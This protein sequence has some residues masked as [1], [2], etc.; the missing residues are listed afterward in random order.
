MSQSEGRVPERWQCRLPSGERP[1]TYM[2]PPYQLRESHKRESLPSDW[3]TRIVCGGFFACRHVARWSRPWS[4]RSSDPRAHLLGRPPLRWVTGPGSSATLKI[5]E[6]GPQGSALRYS[7]AI[8]SASNSR[9]LFG[10]W[11]VSFSMPPRWAFSMRCSAM[12]MY[13]VAR[14]TASCS[15]MPSSMRICT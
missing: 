3:L 13:I 11:P 7:E 9:M 8:F 12:A 10:A 15:D 4:R 6:P 1:T 5:G 2:E 14:T